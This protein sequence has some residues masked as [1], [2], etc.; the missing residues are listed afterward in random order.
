M[1]FGKTPLVIRGGEHCET[2]EIVERLDFM[3]DDDGTFIVLHF[4]HESGRV[5]GIRAPV[6][7]EI[8][9]EYCENSN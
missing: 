2:G 7:R 6:T 1:S 9:E 4:A 3:E 8:Y 5:A